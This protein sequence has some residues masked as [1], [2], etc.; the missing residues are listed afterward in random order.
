MK[1]SSYVLICMFL[2]GSVWTQQV[3]KRT[4]YIEKDIE[5]EERIDNAISKQ[6][7]SDVEYAASEYSKILKICSGIVT[8]YRSSNISELKNLESIIYKYKGQNFSFQ[9]NNQK[10]Q[11]NI[12]IREIFDNFDLMLTPKQLEILSGSYKKPVAKLWQIQYENI[13]RGLNIGMRPYL[14]ALLKQISP[15][16]KKRLVSFAKDRNTALQLSWK[17]Y[18]PKIVEEFLAKNPLQLHHEGMLVQLGDLYFACGRIDQ[19]LNAWRTSIQYFPNYQRILTV[20]KIAIAAYLNKD[21][22]IYKHL[23]SRYRKSNKKMTIGGENTS[24][25]KFLQEI[26]KKFSHKPGNGWFSFRGNNANSGTTPDFDFSKI[27]RS[28]TA[29]YR[30][31]NASTQIS[32]PI[33]ANN[34]AYIRRPNK[35]ICVD[36]NDIL[37]QKSMFM[38]PK[39]A[40]DDIPLSP[41][42]FKNNPRYTTATYNNGNVY[43]FT[44]Q[45]KDN[46][47]FSR[48]CARDAKSGKLLWQWGNAKQHFNFSPV[49]VGNK[50]FASV[51]RFVGE[52]STEVYCF[53]ISDDNDPKIQKRYNR[54]G[55]LLWRRFIGSAI[56]KDYYNTSDKVTIGSGIV[57]G[58]GKIYCCTNLGVVAAIDVVD[59]HIHWLN[60]YHDHKKQKYQL[61]SNAIPRKIKWENVPPIV[62]NGKLYVTPTDSDKLYIY[63]CFSGALQRVYPD[64]TQ[65]TVFDRV[66]GVDRNGIV[67][68]AGQGNHNKTK[69]VA[70]QEEQSREILWEKNIFGAIN[71]IGSMSDNN[72]YFPTD[73][74]LLYAI[75][76][77]DGRS[78]NLNY[79]KQMA[80]LFTRRRLKN[81]TI[82][83]FQH[84]KKSYFVLS[85]RSSILFFAKPH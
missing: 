2:I 73:T 3:Q 43:Y 30:Y 78:L 67:Y 70:L 75:R 9:K 84:N 23:S 26:P 34:L 51:T 53:D 46:S 10:P 63:D 41:R 12:Y 69:V 24:I 5:I 15:D 8:K 49:V 16:V 54:K 81:Y 6:I 38:K 76:K 44:T 72:I 25:G 31:R 47:K 28:S 68:I 50:L 45:R 58:Y 7:S 80:Y 36:L 20:A 21:M 35:L 48:I 66:L 82:N 61:R 42:N 59:G 33:F 29:S 74:R 77:S 79:D 4:I 13:A 57:S 19:A 22:H 56:E 52:T 71:G 27:R 14:H 32:L 60:Q 62:K 37:P 65:N 64:N 85:G 83:I 55:K 17:N 18:N 1:N 40:V 39:W 11:S